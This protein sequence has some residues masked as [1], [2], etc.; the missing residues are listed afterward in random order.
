MRQVMKHLPRLYAE[1][2]Q[3]VSIGELAKIKGRTLE[4]GNAYTS[5]R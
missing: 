4:I 5:L 3:V 2:Y 1:G